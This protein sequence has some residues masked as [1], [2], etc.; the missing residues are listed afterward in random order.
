MNEKDKE[1]AREA[2][3]NKIGDFQKCIAD[4][5]HSF[6]PDEALEILWYYGFFDAGYNAHSGCERQ[7]TVIHSADDL[8]KKTGQYLVREK[9]KHGRVLIY[10]FEIATRDDYATGGYKKGESVNASY[11]VHAFRSWMPIPPFTE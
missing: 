7:W 6:P 11:E 3:K 4:L 1:A 9:G 2:A 10:D 5:M 8:P